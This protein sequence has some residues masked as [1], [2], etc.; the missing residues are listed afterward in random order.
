MSTS[1]APALSVKYGL[2]ETQATHRLDVLSCFDIPAG[3]RILEIGC[4]QGDFTA[5]LA[6][7]VAAS[8]HQGHVDAVDP[9][10]LDYGTPET[11]GQ[12]QARLKS[13]DIGEYID[14]HRVDPI[15]FLA[16]AERDAGDAAHIYDAAILC[17]CLWYFR[18]RD[19]IAATLKAAKGKCKQLCVAEWALSTNTGA[20]KA[21]S[22]SHVSAGYPH[23]LTA[24]A[25]A[26]CEA[27]I[28][29]SDE[30]IRTPVSPKQIKELAAEVGWTLNNERVIT[31]D[32][33]LDDARWEIAM[34]LEEEEDGSS[35]FL[36]RAREHIKEEAVITLLGS[37]LESVKSAITAVGG[38]KN[39]RC[40]D[41]WV[42]VFV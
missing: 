22:L 26:A 38:V 33:K 29:A 25:R 16:S 12:A 6:H 20:N 36:K 11:L 15:K 31:P 30:N 14:F 21:Q 40:M 8:G 17:H 41:V 10:P 28:P 18:S 24:L 3:S 9:A 19:E 34:V 4:G 23:V 42:G 32:S 37:M 13:Y 7:H 35:A 39:V 2:L 5:V 27:H 1:L